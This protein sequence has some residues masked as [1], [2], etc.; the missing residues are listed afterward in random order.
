M[1]I[2]L[3]YAPTST[4]SDD[5]DEVSDSED[6]DYT[7]DILVENIPLLYRDCMDVID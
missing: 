4:V 6:K 5:L 2:L 7:K 3:I 1:I